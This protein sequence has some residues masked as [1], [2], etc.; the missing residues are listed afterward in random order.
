MPS[1]APVWKQIGF[2][3]VV[4]DDSPESVGILRAALELGVEATVFP[5]TQAMRIPDDGRLDPSGHA[6]LAR[7]VAAAL[8]E[9]RHP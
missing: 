2:T 9:R 6:S 4:L 7:H 3:V 1:R 8:R 5:M